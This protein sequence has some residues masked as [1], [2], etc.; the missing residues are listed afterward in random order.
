MEKMK[1]K[2]QNAYKEIAT[3]IEREKQL[4]VV[5]QKMEL[6]RHLQNKSAKIMKPKREQKGSKL[7]APVYKF[8]YMR[9]K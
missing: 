1:K 7:S 8:Q 6:K 9:K 4:T 5:Q 3:R 2:K